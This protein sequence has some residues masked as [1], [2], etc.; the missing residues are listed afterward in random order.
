MEKGGDDG[1]ECN[2][3][4]PGRRGEELFTCIELTVTIRSF[5]FRASFVCQ[6][7]AIEAKAILLGATWRERTAS[8]R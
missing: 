4:V 3:K 8:K 6:S 5:Q 2:L 1:I 7:V